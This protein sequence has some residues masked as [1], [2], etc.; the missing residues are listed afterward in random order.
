MLNS[1]FDGL[2]SAPLFAGIALAVLVGWGAFRLFITSYWYIRA[3]PLQRARMRHAWSVSM[4]W[5]R[6]AP[7]LGLARIDENT[8]GRKDMQGK[9]VKPTVVVPRLKVF[10]EPWGIRAVVKTI[11]KVGVEEFEKAAGWLADAWDCETVEVNRLKAG[12]LE[13]RGLVGNPLDDH[14]AYEVPAGDA[15]V[16]PLGRNPWARDLVIPLKDL[17]GIKVAGMPGFGKTMLMLGW[18]A[19]L[20]GRSAV[21]FAVFDGKTSDPRYGDWGQVGHRAMFIVGDNPETAHQRLTDLVRLIKDRPAQ[22]VEERGTH[23]F[24]KDGPTDTIPLV[25]VLMDECHNYIDASGLRGKDK[26]LIESN[27]R[28]MRTIAKEGRGLGVIPIVGTQKQTGDAIPTAVRDNLEVGVCFAVSTIDAAEAALG[29]GIRKDED[30]QPTKLRDKD[31]FTGV[32][33]VTGVPGL[34]G[35][36]DRIRVGDIDEPA[37]LQLVANSVYLR[38]DVIPAPAPVLRDAGSAG[39]PLQKTEDQ[40]TPKTTRRR[41]AS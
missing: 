16:L 22:L 20:A 11:P 4:R 9:A 17:S 34:G 33:V 12:L 5:R 24:W 40:T 25:L 35:Q 3:T 28:L 38:R 29:D 27:Q 10:P 37:M 18:L 26:E 23:K 1:V 13:L 19:G 15:W 8:K 7:N 36:F 31:R 32:C 14:F 41:K 39:V 21:Q 2:E 6:L 30:N